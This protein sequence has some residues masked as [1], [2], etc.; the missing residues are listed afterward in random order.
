M[1]KSDK[2]IIEALQSMGYREASP[3]LWLKPVGY[4]SATFNVSLM[5]WASWF[6]PANGGNAQIYTSDI[7]S[8]DTDQF[9]EWLK[10]RESTGRLDLILPSSF[11]F[12]TKKEQL[13][14]AL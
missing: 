5:E 1:K 9:I 7:F 10:Y 4:C 12:M 2:N 11:E 8:G 13:E 6:R 14:I 3:G